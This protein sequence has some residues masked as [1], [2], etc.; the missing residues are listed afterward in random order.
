M[1]YIREINAFY[2]WIETNPIPASAINLW[3][4]LMHINNKCRWNAE[5]TVA[6]STLMAKTGFQRR[7]IF[8]AR[9]TLV[10]CGRLVWTSNGREKSATY[11]LIPFVS[12]N[13]SG[14][15]SENQFENPSENPS[16]S[17][18]NPPSNPPDFNT[19]QCSDKDKKGPYNWTKSDT[20][21]ARISK[22]KQK[23]KQNNNK[24]PKGSMSSY[25]DAASHHP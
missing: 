23:H 24:E 14:N 21:G 11:R 4:A 3:Y 12:E 5:F 13:Q 1:N 15:Q 9:K 8:K 25:D 2:K 7:T 10:D 22:H 18:V 6:A 16:A 20:K 19:D 17:H